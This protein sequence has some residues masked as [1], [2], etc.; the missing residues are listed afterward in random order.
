M[1]QKMQPNFGTLQ[2]CVSMW[3]PRQQ[4]GNI[5]SLKFNCYN[6][7]DL[8]PAAHGMKCEILVREYNNHQ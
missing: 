8:I 4:I 3:T 2:S 6:L 7:M 5:Y 1:E